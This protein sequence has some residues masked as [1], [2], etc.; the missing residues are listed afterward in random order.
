LVSIIRVVLHVLDST[1]PDGNNF[2][3]IL[4]MPF[5]STTMH[6]D[7]KPNDHDIL[8]QGM[9]VFSVLFPL[10]NLEYSKP[11]RQ[12]YSVGSVILPCYDAIMTK[13]TQF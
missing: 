6:F 11:L 13:C 10:G 4:D 5:T 7:G 12:L 3:T 1:G 2:C 9:H 8:K